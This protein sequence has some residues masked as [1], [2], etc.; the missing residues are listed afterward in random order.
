MIAFRIFPY[1][2][3]LF[4]PA[5]QTPFKVLFNISINPL[6][7]G[8]VVGEPSGSLHRRFPTILLYIYSDLNGI[9]VYQVGEKA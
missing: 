7:K 1:D 4:Q 8:G 3:S 6:W 9:S 5:L 2:P